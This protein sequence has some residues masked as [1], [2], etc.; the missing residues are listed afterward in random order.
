MYV[1]S[2]EYMKTRL[3]Q[4]G[5][6]IVDQ[7]KQY[8]KARPYLA[9]W[10]RESDT[11]VYVDLRVWESPPLYRPQRWYMNWMHRLKVK[12]EF[13][14]WLRIHKWLGKRRYDA[15]E[16]FPPIIP[17]IRVNDPPIIDQIVDVKI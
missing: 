2:I 7:D 17:S 8:N 3:R 13:N 12:S 1:N 5:Y 9:V 15:V 11:M 6:E 14:K 10:P 16:V 4:N